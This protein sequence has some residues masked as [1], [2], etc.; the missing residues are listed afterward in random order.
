[1]MPGLYVYVL[2]LLIGI[3]SGG[4][5]AWKVQTIRFQAKEATRA[6][7]N[8]VAER[9]A[10]AE[11]LRKSNDVIKALNAAK[12]RE[13]RLRIDANNARLGLDGLRDSAVQ[14]LLASSHDLASCTAHGTIQNIVLLECGD[15]YK[16]V[17]ASA[18]LWQS[19][20][21]TLMDAFP[22]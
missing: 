18:D 13:N 14:S 3:A 9:L 19:D 21:Q 6:E 2:V 22:K 5:A 1:M 16:E 7:Q 8:V 15:R 12:A 11:N 17:A 10:A 4:T 20:A